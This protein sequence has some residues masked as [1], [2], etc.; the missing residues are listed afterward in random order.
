VQNKATIPKPARR[1][2]VEATAV[3]LSGIWSFGR[4]YDSGVKGE[5]EKRLRKKT[6]VVK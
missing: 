4:L 1:L 2:A 5:K 3:S 6:D